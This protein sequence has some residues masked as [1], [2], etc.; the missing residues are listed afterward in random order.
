[1]ADLDGK[2]KTIEEKMVQEQKLLDGAKKMLSND[3]NRNVMSHVE[4][5]I[6]QC[7]KNLSYLR[8][9]KKKLERRRMER[10]NSDGNSSLQ[11]NNLTTSIS[12]MELGSQET[13]RD[14]H[15]SRLKQT[16]LE[17][18][19]AESPLS[20]EM[21]SFRLQEIE[22]KKNVEK[23]MKDAYSRLNSVYLRDP[24]VGDNWNQ[25]RADY[26]DSSSKHRIYSQALRQYEGVN[27]GA[28]DD[29][30]EEEAIDMT[31][32]KPGLRR[33]MTGVLFV[34]IISGRYLQHLSE[35]E[36]FVVCKID[37]KFRSQ[38]KFS[39]MDRW[40]EEFEFAVEK[41]NELEIIIYNVQ[42]EGPPVPI[43]LF[44][45]PISELTDDLRK[46][47]AGNTGW[48]PADATG[49]VKSAQASA[50][51]L[52]HP[53]NTES[54][55][56]WWKVEPTGEFLMR[57]KFVKQ[58]GKKRVLSR[59][60]RQGA[61]RKNKEIAAELRGHK[62][63]ARQFYQVM[64]CAFCDKFLVNNTAF[65][66]QDCRYFCHEE[67]APKVVLKC[68]ATP[69]Y[70]L[71]ADEQKLD[72]LH[73]IHHR[74]ESTTNL[75]A[76]WCCH[77][78]YMIP[79]GRGKGK[80]CTECA[81]TCHESCQHLVPNFC[82]MTMMMANQILDME[83]TKSHRLSKPALVETQDVLKKPMAPPTKKPVKSSPTPKSA[84]KKSQSKVSIQDFHLVSVLGRGNFGKVMLAEE[85]STRNLY[86]IKIL[87]K[88]FIVENN[89]VE[90]TRSEKRVFLAANRERH[91]FLVGLHSCFQS[92][93]SIY[94]V[95]EYISGGDLMWHIQR[96]QFT[97][98]RAKFYAIEVLL[99]L[100]YF[101]QN[102]IV[103]RDLKLDNILLA[104]DGHIKIADYG[105]CKENMSFGATTLTFCGTPEFMAPEIILEQPYT[106]A[107]DWWAFGVLLYEMI[108]GQS[109]FHG[110]D[111]D[112]I[113][114]AILEDDILYPYNLARESV[115][116]LQKLLNRDPTK[117]LGGGP[118]DASEVKRHPYFKGIVWDD[119][120][121]KRIPPPHIP[122]INSRTDTSNFDEEFTKEKPVITPSNSI[123]SSADQQEFQ[124]FS[125]VADWVKPST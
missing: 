67:C 102:N 59:L 12:K 117:R 52:A 56:S 45:I 40:N 62:F 36:A 9:E 94:F 89:E 44:W 53:A 16:A 88:E 115:S 7:E 118:E 54:V 80:R 92:D 113:F 121:A 42:R 25:V 49:Q 64:T 105:L 43:G 4:Q 82:G 96:Q 6:Q 120:F 37:G 76:K 124:G 2:L 23:N 20:R 71:D 86:A 35:P 85:K 112:E 47:N 111:E 77:C 48:A 106:R 98:T 75:M 15:A 104:A 119:Y 101:H 5:R 91:P 99:A 38:T 61:V 70:E 34:R 81:V 26:V 21:I 33:P 78:G 22:Y 58:A 31:W 46:K 109:P 87:K 95:M 17:L 84:S 114:D 107:V 90:G 55:E 30:E 60:G 73:R 65:Q 3:I 83:K 66:C 19:K 72:L 32:M 57:L 68:I 10:T 125:Y 27:I 122:V 74:F 11:T 18:R 63:V 8:S 123:L 97:E 69:N 14:P 110:E 13:I 51:D 93:S 24:N 108:L 39:R 29:E 116:I 50:L 41:A 28:F 100:E 103:Y 79:L 1:M